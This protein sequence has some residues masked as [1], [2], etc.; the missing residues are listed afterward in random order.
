MSSASAVRH[1]PASHPIELEVPLDL[2]LVQAD[3]AQLERVFSNL[4]ENAIKFSPPGTPVRVSGT[5]AAG[6]VTVR[7]TDH[8]RG[9]P[10]PQRARVFEPFFRGR[11]EREARRAPARASAWP[12]AAASSRPTGGASAC[13]SGTQPGPRS[14]CR[15]PVARQ[16]AAAGS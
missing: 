1:L 10:G 9:I 14:R 2:P 8:G 13:R 6:R 4:L 16:P 7:V 5:A 12:S 11:G 3:A 15:F